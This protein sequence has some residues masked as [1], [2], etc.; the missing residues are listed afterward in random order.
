MQRPT[1][2]PGA[3]F[4]WTW[5]PDERANTDCTQPP[6]LAKRN[7]SLPKSCV[8]DVTQSVL[9]ESSCTTQSVHPPLH[10]LDTTI[11]PQ[12]NLVLGFIVTELQ[13]PEAEKW[14]RQQLKP[15]RRTWSLFLTCGIKSR[16]IARFLTCLVQRRSLKPAVMLCN[17]CNLSDCWMEEKCS[18]LSEHTEKTGKRKEPAG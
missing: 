18:G 4:I 9:V 15:A 6:Q 3:R 7:T 13:H 5:Q 2:L 12:E 11:D 8:E 17:I 16:L 1:S 14:S 10:T